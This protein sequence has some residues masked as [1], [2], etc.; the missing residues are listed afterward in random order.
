MSLEIINR[1]TALDLGLK[2]YYTGEPCKHGHIAERKVTNGACTECARLLTKRWR[3]E[4][5]V[6]GHNIAGKEIPSVEYLNEC[7]EYHEDGY[8]TWK[9]RPRH[10]FSSDRSYK[11]VNAM[12]AGKVAG[13]YHA[14]NSYLEIR[15]DGDLYKGHRIIW[16]MLKNEEPTLIVDHIDGD[17]K[18][19]KIENLRLATSQNNARNSNKRP[20]LKNASS[21][22]KG[23]HYSDSKSKWFSCITVDDVCYNIGFETEIEA[24]LDYDKR[25]KELYGEF[26][27]LNFPEGYSYE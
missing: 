15:L 26:A 24:A 2:R 21:V 13:H 19:N 4:G 14:I 8:L 5:C 6:D 16:K 1:K 20:Q 12:L 9:H 7:F 10:H 25:A 27:K 11:C 23:V 3:E 17:P 22:Y 18:N